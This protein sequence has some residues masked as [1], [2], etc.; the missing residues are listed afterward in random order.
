LEGE[1][2]EGSL[3]DATGNV[4]SDI[5]QVK[6][7]R[8]P[9]EAE[10]EYAARGGHQSVADYKYAGSNDLNSVGWYWQNSGDEWLPGDDDDWDRDTVLA[11]NCQANPGGQKTANELGLYDMSANVWEWCHDWYGSYG[12]ER[13]TNPTGS[14]TGSERVERG[15]SYYPAASCCRVAERGSVTPSK[16]FVADLGFRVCRT[17]GEVPT[18][19]PSQSICDIVYDEFIRDKKVIQTFFGDD[20]NPILVARYEYLGEV[21]QVVIDRENGIVVFAVETDNDLDYSFEGSTLGMVF[22]DCG[23]SNEL[24]LELEKELASNLFLGMIP[25]NGRVLFVMV[26]NEDGLKMLYL[27]E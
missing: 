9:T 26:N 27:M 7:Y 13:Q 16:S 15:G 17:G 8:L 21:F 14:G 19:P 1:R 3:L 4:T 11:N 23:L 24:Y 22:E 2:S 20:G 10:W 5:T 6:G 12:S 18:P 25:F